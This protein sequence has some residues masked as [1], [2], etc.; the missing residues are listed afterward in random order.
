MEHGV[1]QPCTF[2]DRIQLMIYV[3]KAHQLPP[4][5]AGE[6]SILALRRRFVR[7]IR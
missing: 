3:F 4:Y 6:E 2:K 5:E 7:I 1:R